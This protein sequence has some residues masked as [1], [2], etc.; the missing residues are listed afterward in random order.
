M[1]QIIKRSLISG[2]LFVSPFALSYGQDTV[3]TYIA[4]DVLKAFINEHSITI[5]HG[6]GPHHLVTFSIGYVYDNKYLRESFIGLSPSQDEYPVMVY[7]GPTA[8]AGYEYRLSQFFYCGVDLY[9]KHLYY[10]DHVFEDQDGKDHA[11]IYK[12]SETSN[13]V[14]GHLNLGFL[15]TIPKTPLLINPS[16]ALGG[17]FKY[18][19]HT[20]EICSG[21][22][23][24]DGPWPEEGPVSERQ[25][26]VSVMM[27][28]NIGIR[29]G[30]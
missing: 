14:G 19:N 24:Y 1:I 8:R 13:F 20:T 25:D 30:K 7:K 26:V 11:V 29:I 27:N 6:L 3:K 15:L 22:E 5:G 16:I 10:K 2:I 12:R 18:R 9:V 23:W 21:D 17:T 28:L 4:Y